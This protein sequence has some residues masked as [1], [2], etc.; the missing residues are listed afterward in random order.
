MLPGG[1]WNCDG[2][3]LDAS[4]VV[5]SLRVLLDVGEVEVL[6][7]VLLVAMLQIGLGRCNSLEK[8]LLYRKY[9]RDGGAILKELY[10]IT[11]LVI[12]YTE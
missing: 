11:T 1:R 5:E 10:R 8:S 6:L 3:T 2:G 12:A 4:H 9:R 7:L